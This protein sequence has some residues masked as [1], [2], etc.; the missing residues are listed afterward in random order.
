MA[1]LSFGTFNDSNLRKIIADDLASG[2]H[3]NPTDQL[4]YFTTAYFHLRPE[5][6]AAE[7]RD[8]GFSDV[9]IIAVEGPAWSAAR[10]REVWDELTTNDRAS[11]SFCR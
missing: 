6:L 2:Q 7:A 4:A 9:H 8:A 3:R 11:W 5:E 1:G 10:F